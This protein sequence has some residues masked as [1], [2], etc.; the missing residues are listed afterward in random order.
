MDGE[1]RSLCYAGGTY[2]VV[3]VHAEDTADIRGD[4]L[5]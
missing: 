1:K 2:R 5:A 3:V 4:E